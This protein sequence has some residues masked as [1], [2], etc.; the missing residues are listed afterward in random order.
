MLNIYDY[1]TNFENKYV[2]SKNTKLNKHC[3]HGEPQ[4]ISFN[5]LFLYLEHFLRQQ[6]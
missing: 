6:R 3:V 4:N 1:V 2:D 5:K